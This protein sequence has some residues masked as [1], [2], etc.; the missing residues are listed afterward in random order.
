MRFRLPP[1]R[2]QHAT[3]FIIFHNAVPAQ[4]FS[5]IEN[6]FSDTASRNNLYF[7]AVRKRSVRTRGSIRQ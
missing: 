6:A 5:A 1:L 7:R 3:V 2:P 4:L